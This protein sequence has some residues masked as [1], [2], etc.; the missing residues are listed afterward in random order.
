ML[1]AETGYVG[2]ETCKRCHGDLWRTFFRNP[3]YKSIASGEEPPERTGCEGCHGPGQ[4][5]VAA[6]GNKAAIVAYSQLE[7]AQVIDRCLGCHAGDVGKSNIR[8]SSHTLANVGCTSCHSIHKSTTSRFLL[9]KAEHNVCYGCHAQ[10]RS[11]FSMPFKHRVNEGFMECSDCHNPHG[12]FAASW[13]MG[14]RP[15]M[16]D[17]AKGPEE[18]CIRCHTD[19]RGPFVFEHASVRVDGCETCHQPHGST[20]ARLLRRPAV[21]TLCLE[22]HNGAG[23]FGRNGAGETAQSSFHNMADPKFRTCTL[24]HARIHGSNSSPLFLR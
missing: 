21:F 19:K 20:N 22:C 8:R 3:H 1:Q 6:M 5:H 18:P 23:N 24:C 16:V 12:T 11:Q 10:V 15:R 4:K 13:R 2:S 7:P 14:D 17:Q 9:A